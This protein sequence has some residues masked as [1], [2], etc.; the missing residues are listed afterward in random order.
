MKEFMVCCMV[1]FSLKKKELFFF[2]SKTIQLESFQAFSWNLSWSRE[3]ARWLPC[4][5]RLQRTLQPWLKQIAYELVFAHHCLVCL[6]VFLL[7][8]MFSVNNRLLRERHTWTCYKIWRVH[9][10][11]RN[12]NV[13][14]KKR[15]IYSVSKRTEYIE[16]YGSNGTGRWKQFIG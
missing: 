13:C 12:L 16:E 2:P 14:K 9:F 3:N 7:L 1:I 6:F 15:T 10:L 11:I 4:R 8:N 5:V